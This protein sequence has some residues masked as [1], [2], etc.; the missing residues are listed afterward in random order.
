MNIG[1]VCRRLPLLLLL[2]CVIGGEAAAYTVQEK[3]PLNGATSVL[4]CGPVGVL[5]NQQITFDENQAQQAFRVR[6]SRSGTHID[7]LITV[8]S[9][10]LIYIPLIPFLAG[11]TVEVTLLDL[12]ALDIDDAPMTWTFTVRPGLFPDNADL[13]LLEIE[14]GYLSNWMNFSQIDINQLFSAGSSSIE[15]MEWDWG[16]MDADGDLDGVII[17]KYH[18]SSDFQLVTIKHE[19][20]VLG[21]SWQ[22]SEVR[23]NPGNITSPISIMLGDVNNN[24][25]QDLIICGTTELKI[26]FDPKPDVL[27]SN[28]ANFTIDLWTLPLTSTVSIGDVNSDGHADLILSSMPDC[29]SDV[30]FLHTAI[31]KCLREFGKCCAR[32]CYNQNSC[33]TFIKPMNN[34]RA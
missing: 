28:N 13:F 32:F 5:L 26:W 29:N 24:S 6:G 25:K 33:R 30:L 19:V 34:S 21:S 8:E 14:A 10:T 9:D 31:G 23:N 12:P 2:L 15:T 27:L 4:G 18:Q 22:V 7:G 11:E 1:T 16:D 3:I 20:S 17:C